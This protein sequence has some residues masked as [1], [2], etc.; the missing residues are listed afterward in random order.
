MATGPAT[1]AQAAPLAGI[2]VV[3]ASINVPA[4]VAGSR[5]AQLGATVTKVEPPEG[6]PVAAASAELYAELTAG[7]AIVRL[8][9]KTEAG[10]TALAE[11]LGAADLLLT[12]SRPSALARIG[13]S[14]PELEQRYPRLVQVAIVGHAAPQQELAGH[15]LTYFAR[16]GLVA[17]P[18]LPRTLMADLH[19]AE[20][21]ATAA[22]ALLLARERGGGGRYLEVALEESAEALSLPWRHG[23][24]SSDGPLGGTYP[25][26]PPLRDERRLDRARS[27]RAPVP[28][29][30]SGGSRRGRRIDRVVQRG[31]SSTHGEG[32]GALGRRARHPA[33]RCALTDRR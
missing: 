23:L 8:D 26:L 24:T 11:L 16:H 15:D 5:L 32:V 6:D 18:A 28:E 31:V 22:A 14:R 12:S 27:A 13:L 25:Y 33:R 3:N 1:L 30:T 29:A 19:G 2:G 4:D 17:P 9:L 20:R 7:Q 21:A 10:Q